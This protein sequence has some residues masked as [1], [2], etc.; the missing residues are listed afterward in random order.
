MK[1]YYGKETKKALNNFPFS[2]RRTRNEFIL[3][4]TQIKKAAALANYKADN[5]SK[6]IRNAI[7]KV[8]DEILENKHA[9]Q[10]PLAYLQGGAGTAIN[11]NVNEVIAN[12]ATL[13]LKN[14][15]KVHPNDHVN[16][17]QSTN[18]VNPSAL[19]ISAFYLLQ[20]LNDKLTSLVKTFEV[21]AKEFKK[22]NK[23]GRTHLQDAIP[24]T[25]GAEFEAYAHNLKRYVAQIK[26][27]ANLCRI[28]NLGGTAIGNS[29]NATPLYIK[30]V[31]RE[32]NKITNGKFYKAKNMIAKTSGQ[33]DFLLISQTVTALCLDLSK[34]AND[35]RFMASG[36][37]G[38]IGEIILPELQ[39]GSSIIPGKVNPIMPETVNQL[40]YLVSGNNVSIEKATEASQMEL[41]VM[42]PIIVEKLIDSIKI[43]TEIISQFDKLCIAGIKANKERCKYH[44]ENSTAYSTLLVPRLG[45]DIVSEIVKK[46]ISTNKTL[47]DIVVGEKY[48]EEKEFNK[49]IS[50]QR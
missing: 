30:E 50:L 22:I 38:G 20:D 13:I 48:L 24:T 33:T 15:V 23:L 7:I 6:D 47:R 39:K 43:T 45:Y 37:R 28:L 42:L 26:I 41:G 34:I 12:I 2:V 25:L 18:D 10:F 40:Y 44:L 19:K 16:Q 49:I 32:L 5:L 9:N 1:L 4:M 21:K 11:M 17:C 35:L 46:S 8:C 36:P 27:S 31:Y 14:K 3:A 29:M